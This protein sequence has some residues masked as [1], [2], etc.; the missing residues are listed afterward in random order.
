[1]NYPLV[2]DQIIN[3]GFVNSERPLA[4]SH[5]DIALYVNTKN[6]FEVVL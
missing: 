4:E 6:S 2:I 1:M 3:I 5:V